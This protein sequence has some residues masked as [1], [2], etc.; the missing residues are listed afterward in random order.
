MNI[1]EFEYIVAIE[2]EG[3]ISKAARKLGISQPSLSSFL[4]QEECR[5]GHKLFHYTK[6]Q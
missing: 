6:R 4:N 2:D 3:N 1:R 5:L